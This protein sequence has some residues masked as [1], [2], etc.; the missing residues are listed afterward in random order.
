MIHLLLDSSIYR[1]D[2]ARRGQNFLALKRLAVAGKLCL[3]VPYFIQQEALSHYESAIQEPIN[4]AVSSLKALAKKDLSDE[5]LWKIEKVK[6]CIK[7]MRTSL[8]ASE[9]KKLEAWF[10]SVKARKHPIASSH[11]ARVA[12]DY[13]A[14]NAPFGQ[15]RQRQD[16]PDSFIYHAICDL[17]S[18][19]KQLH[20]V[21]A[22]HRLRNACAQ[23]TEIKVHPSL[24]E[25]IA[26]PDCADLLAEEYAKVNVEGVLRFVRENPIALRIDMEQLLLAT[27]PYRTFRD[28]RI[29][30]DN[31]EAV[32][33]GLCEPGSVEYDADSASYYGDGVFGIPFS[34]ANEALIDYAIFKSDYYALGD[35]SS[36]RI[37]VSDDLNR[38][39]FSAHEHVKL[40]VEG[41][42]LFELPLEELEKSALSVNRIEELVLEA[43][44]RL[45]EEL[46]IRLGGSC[47]E[48]Y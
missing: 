4:G 5:A 26:S 47:E 2:P 42:V 17:A 13:F 9:A 43:E 7:E 30:D 15:K 40:E 28:P 23:H 19:L 21:C 22:D 38:H 10:L 8:A 48:T 37:S 11:G 41:I 34:L 14:G 31:G 25:F 33:V 36:R 27:V 1:S 3:H 39:Y 29:R 20:V 18:D 24:Q 46:H 45:D 12:H 16:I 44:A 35:D 6:T 32:I